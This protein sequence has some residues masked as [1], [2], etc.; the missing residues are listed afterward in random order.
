MYTYYVFLWS[1]LVANLDYKRLNMVTLAFAAC[2]RESCINIP[3]YDDDRVE[4]QREQ[5]FVALHP[6]PNSPAGLRVNSRST[7]DILDND[8]MQLENTTND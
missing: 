5:F 6:Y 8:S 1:H 3:I 2:R 4:R 7:V